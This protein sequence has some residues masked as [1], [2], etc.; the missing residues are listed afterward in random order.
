MP[1]LAHSLYAIVESRV[2]VLSPRALGSIALVAL[3]FVALLFPRSRSDPQWANVGHVWGADWSS[4]SARG[5]CHVD[6]AQC[7]AEA[8]YWANVKRRSEKL[9]G[10]LQPLDL[11][12]RGTELFIV[13]PMYPCPFEERVGEWG[14]G[15]KWT[16]L[17]PGVL[18]PN[19]TV[20]SIGSHGLY[21]FEEQFAQAHPSAIFTFDPFL[22]PFVE[23]KMRALPFL[24]FRAVGLSGEASLD[25]YKSKY[26]TKL[27]AT[28]ARL[29]ALMNHSYVD[30]FKIDCEGCELEVIKDMTA[31]YGGPQPAKLAIHG[32]SLPFG[33]I[34]MEFHNLNKPAILLPAIYAL[35]NLGYRMFHAEFNAICTSCVEISF[36]HEGLVKP[37]NPDSCS[38]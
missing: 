30:V 8:T 14:D 3:V 38:Y 6:V 20:Y 9:G 31:L 29:L 37:S 10:V 5:M 15:G 26:P 23:Y 25:K 2:S 12:T 13:S 34:L 36:I 16:C 11:D 35:E 33:Q 24:Q 7:H 28:L 27:F 1:S 22:N 21:D 4:L 32:G 17:I 18:Q 19:T